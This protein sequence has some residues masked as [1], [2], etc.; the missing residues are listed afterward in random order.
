MRYRRITIRVPRSLAEALR[1][2]AGELGLAPGT[3]LRMI[4]MERA[5]EVPSPAET[6]KIH[7]D[8]RPDQYDRLLAIA[9]DR[10]FRSVSALVRA[11]LTDWGKEN[12]KE[13]DR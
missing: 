6:V 10:G 8:L 2:R 13:D 7:M 12:E 11:A 9:Q 4:A 1:K 5:E 3:L